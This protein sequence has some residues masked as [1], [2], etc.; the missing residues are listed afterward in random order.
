LPQ[1]S[2]A[3]PE[4]EHSKRSLLN[5]VNLQIKELK[6]T[7]KSAR[8]KKSS[9]Q[10]NLKKS[11]V[12]IAEAET[13]LNNIKGKFSVLHHV[14]NKLNLRHAVLKKK[15]DIQ[16]I[17]LSQQAHQAYLLGQHQHLKLL[18]NQTN[19]HSVSRMLNYFRHL[20]RARVS[21]ISNLNSDLKELEQNQR[22][23]EAHTEQLRML[24]QQRQKQKSR[25]QRYKRMQQSLIKQLSHKIHSRGTNLKELVTNKETLEK[26]IRG[27]KPSY[28]GSSSS[29][30]RFKQL[31]GMLS[32]PTHGRI[33]KH[34]G[35]QLDQSGL[36][37]AGV[38]IRAPEGTPV[39]AVNSG[40][41]AFAD[42]LKGF[43]LILIVEH[44]NGYMT[45]YGHN[46][47]LFK[48][49][50][51]PVEAGE[52]IAYTGHSGGNKHSGLYFEIRHNGHPENPE[53]WC[54]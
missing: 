14:L 36:K 5:K 51:D 4:V 29:L 53:R 7:I 18:I 35:T 33:T 47:N 2:Y 39:R 12:N 11:D 3:S 24:V 23:I 43:G 34:F 32:W 41:V 49:P 17:E 37:Y 21:F 50:G 19:P 38:F 15:I 31:K 45:L 54:S 8:K 22:Q 6:K 25:L 16:K 13:N 48:R 42:W 10:K 46:R 1:I 44:S 20:N 40:T 9:I 52:I 30:T 27:L 28:H 26:I